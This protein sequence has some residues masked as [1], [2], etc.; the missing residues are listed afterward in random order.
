MKDFKGFTLIE[1]IAAMAII[2]IGLVSLLALFPTG[3]GLNQ[4]SVST[5]QGAILCKSMIEEIKKAATSKTGPNDTDGPVILTPPTSS[6]SLM[7]NGDQWWQFGKYREPAAGDEREVFPDNSAYE[8]SVLFNPNYSQFTSADKIAQVVVTAYWP[9]VTGSGAPVEEA[10]KKQQS[11][12]VVS[13]I[14]YQT[15]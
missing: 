15:P 12:K 2:T 5:T 10:K 3:L 4:Q 14:R 6:D 1:V 8:V 11:V 9:R 13:F 7:N